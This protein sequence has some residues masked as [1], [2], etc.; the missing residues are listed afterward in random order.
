VKTKTL[1][2][3]VVATLLCGLTAYAHHSFAGTYDLKKQVRIEGKLIR[4]L[5]RNPH[6][7]VHVEAPDETGK[8]QQWSVEWTGLPQLAGAG[9]T[10]ST[11]KVGDPVVITGNPTRTPG[12]HRMRMVTF[13]RTSDGFS[14][15]NRRG[16]VVE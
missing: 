13:R 11:L 8:M 5:W 7:F 14:W 12:E 2:L 4:L 16:E 6:S 3:V 9:I 10:S 15:G 1:V